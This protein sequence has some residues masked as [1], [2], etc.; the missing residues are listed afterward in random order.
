GII[1]LG[2]Q[3]YTEGWEPISYV[4][5]ALIALA[6]VDIFWDRKPLYDPEKKK[7][8]WL[9]IALFIIGVIL[10]AR[11][12]TAAIQWEHKAILLG[13]VGMIY[14][15]YAFYMSHI[16]HG[17]ADAKALMA[18][19]MLFPLYPRLLSF[20]LLPTD[21]LLEL[22]FPFALLVLMASTIASLAIPFALLCGNIA[23]RDL[24]FPHALLGY[25]TGIDE[26]PKFCWPMEVVE[27]G[28]VVSIYF[29]KRGVDSAE[30]FRTL[31]EEGVKEAWVTPK[32]PFLIPMWVGLVLS[33]F[34]GNALLLLLR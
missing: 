18:I 2:A 12:L 33:I 19:A 11:L 21:T 13:V 1:L 26:D 31:R 8:W 14:M 5:L 16:L 30:E 6:Y 24:R 17:G 9:G 23:R 15:F 34:V 28:K 32:I 20:P 10:L 29:R 25:R 3:M 27:E 22:F 4:G 7:I